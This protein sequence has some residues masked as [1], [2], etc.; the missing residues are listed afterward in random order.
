MPSYPALRCTLPY[1]LLL[2]IA[3]YILLSSS[4]NE[5]KQQLGSS[6]IQQ[7]DSIAP[8]QVTILADL[9]DSLQ[10]EI[11]E[12]AKTPVPKNIPIPSTPMSFY[13]Q[14]K[15][16]QSIVYINPPK[17][18]KTAFSPVLQQ[19]TTEQGLAQDVMS[20][21]ITDRNGNL[22][23]GTSVGG[24]SKFN[25]N[26]F[27]NYTN[28]HGLIENGI[29]R[30]YEDR[31]GNIWASTG[32]GASKFDGSTFNT[33]GNFKGV[34][35][36]LEDHAG[37]F[38]FCTIGYGLYKYTGDTIIQY[39]EED[40]LSGNKVY[41]ISEDKNGIF[42]VA[43]NKGLFSFDGSVFTPIS[44]H[45][46]D[47]FV[48]LIDK[49]E[50][51]WA[52]TASGY[53]K[54]DGER[55]TTFPLPIAYNRHIYEDRLGNIWFDGH[56]DG[57]W[58]YDGQAVNTFYHQS[59]GFASA[60][61]HSGNLWFCTPANGIIKYSGPAFLQ[62]SQNSIRSIFEDQEGILWF[63]G[64]SNG[65][66]RFDG[67]YIIDF[68]LQVNLWC[69]YQDRSRNIWAGCTDGG[70]IKFDGK[71]YTFYT[72]LNGLP[73]LFV[74][75]ITQDSK[76]NI[77]IGTQTG[78]S[79]FDGK[80]FTTFRTKQGLAGAMVSYILEDETGVLLFGTNNGLTIYDGVSFTNY[81]ISKTQAGNDIR[82]MMRDQSGNLWI[83]T[84]GG[85]VIRWDG[86]SFHSFT[87]DHGLPDNIV[88]QLAKTKEGHVIVGT[89]VGIAL[90]TGFSS[91]TVSQSIDKSN[92][93]NP[94]NYPAQ[95]KLSNKDLQDL[96]PVFENYN[97]KTGYPIMDVNRGQHAILE[98]S[99]GILWI[100]SGAVKSGLMRFDYSSL[101]KN[102]NPP[103]LNIVS[104]QIDNELVC[105]NDLLQT[106]NHTYYPSSKYELIAASAAVTEEVAAFG[107]AMSESQRKDMR[108]KFKGVRLDSIGKFYHVPKNLVLPYSH[109]SIT[110]EFAAIE[111][112]KPSLVQYQYKLEGYDDFWSTPANVTSAN[113][114]NM[115]EG[116]Y[117][118]QLKA[119]SPS[120]IWSEP[121]TYTFTVL[122]P[123]W[124]TWWAYTLYVFL[125]VGLI[126]EIVNFF[127]RRLQLH[128]QLK[129]EQDEAIRL[130]ELDTFKSQLFTNL[131]HEFRTP[132]TVILGMAK[133][134][135]GG[136]WNS[137]VA[138]NEK[139]KISQGLKMIENN[140]K[141]LLQLINQL[142]DLSKLENK[143]FKLQNIQGDIIPYLRYVTESFQSYA[144][145]IGLS[146]RFVSE[147]NSLMMDFDPEQMKQILTNLISNALKF[148]PSGGEVIVKGSLSEGQLSI[149]VTDTG[150]GISEKDLPYVMDRFYQADSSTTR[151]AQGTGIGLAHTQELLKV[152]GGN[153]SLQSEVGKGTSIT[154][155]LP[156]SH[157]ATIIEEEIVL[158][159]IPH[160]SLTRTNADTITDVT[161]SLDQQPSSNENIPQLLIIEDNRDVVEY[162]KSC[163][164]DR[165]RIRIAY[166]GKAGV[167]KALEEIP[168][169]IISDVMMP[170]MDGF[171]VCNALKNDERTSH[172]PI[173]LL[174][175]KADAASR[176]AGLR[177]GADA[178]MA[179]PFN[180]EE[181]HIHISML[182]E[183]RRRMA[184][185]FSKLLQ[186]GTSPVTEES[187]LPE[188]IQFEDAFMK[189]VHATI[190]DHYTDEYFSLPE[191]C[192][193]LVMSRSQL[194]RKMKAV[195]DIA[196]SDL[197]RSYR[198]NKARTLLEQGDFTVAE[199]AYKVGFKDPSYFSKLFQEEFGVQPSAVI[200][201]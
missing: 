13:M 26:S 94:E 126:Y 69:M 104:I 72:D 191:L 89:N 22:W 97:P 31:T 44:I 112:D 166:N 145:D 28:S 136:T 189:K 33:F 71:S 61:D 169:F 115:Y 73:D 34:N 110:I 181:L 78:L 67:E 173:I 59:N 70:L 109:N 105:W 120:G 155:L 19:Y 88:T 127:R 14:H 194:F 66:T 77:W 18:I 172:I 159:A 49:N 86:I 138:S 93:A 125:F 121:L 102:N 82:S 65:I 5:Q 152:M 134:L 1:F 58:Y 192:Q 7:Q 30:I 56:H 179:K 184:A 15:V 100:A 42:W 74:Q 188:V 162:L 154:V 52:G 129:A 85:G 182:L 50:N 90:L 137:I 47:V 144:E 12:L 198:L 180:P 63:A 60:E 24:I 113:F 197:I 161:S 201:L 153:I 46:E 160:L 38:W 83:G 196:P 122:P 171:Q 101:Y 132:L 43:T 16:G 146:I 185:H 190:E 21:A 48:T 17:K 55:I 158:P 174:T 41:H 95:N 45:T 116:T 39:T 128:H 36:I 2:S 176:L 177:R 156:I 4:C 68:G 142:L 6:L 11:K 143:S 164:E 149:N 8:S 9:P 135:S 111:P 195:A 20:C 108:K 139:A 119:S 92:A 91:N 23:F 150:I 157:E 186:S 76:G 87:V 170:E 29:S 96:T 25:G 123:W 3:T 114:G 131:T 187:N 163:L 79:K 99:K 130:K 199:V 81:T 106:E 64:N 51:V 118:F 193:L 117:R 183:N 103:S 148:T 54:Y 167:E 200:K 35:S 53:I 62:L 141:N 84:Y 124:R 80:S 10:P 178:Y 37:N 140:G 165:Y 75:F 168:D 57:L 27:T 147:I 133:Q 98:D 107:K 151:V 40:G 175:A 32:A